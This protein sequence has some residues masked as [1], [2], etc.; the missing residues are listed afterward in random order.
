LIQLDGDI[1]ARWASL[2]ITEYLGLLTGAEYSDA[3]D[4]WIVQGVQNA[5]LTI[6]NEGDSKS[7]LRAFSFFK[8]GTFFLSDE[9]GM[10]IEELINQSLSPSDKMIV[11]AKEYLGGCGFSIS[12]LGGDSHVLLMADAIRNF[13]VHSEI[14]DGDNWSRIHDIL[15]NGSTSL[16]RCGAKFVT[17]WIDQ[18]EKLAEGQFDVYRRVLLSVLYRHSGQLDKALKVSEIVELPRGKLNGGVS[19]IAV[20]CTTRAGTMM[21]LAENQPANKAELLK[22]TRLTLN[23]A[24][25]MSGGEAEEIRGAYM[26]LK[27]LEKHVQ[28][29]SHLE[30]VHQQM[31]E[32]GKLPS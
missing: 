16:M 19:T 20:L 26:R 27:S 7:V 25:A 22:H 9:S 2:A 14:P 28:E 8:S 5:S 21:D 13:E 12:E 18:S 1:V 10:R 29:E 31:Q 15:S 23:K 30:K 24:Y 11:S 4:I 32:V 3:D 6:S 17:K